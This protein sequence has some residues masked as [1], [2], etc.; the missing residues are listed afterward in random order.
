[1]QTWGSACY[2]YKIPFGDD[3]AVTRE[4]KI[5]C[6]GRGKKE[7]LGF[8][9]IGGIFGFLSTHT[10]VGSLTYRKHTEAIIYDE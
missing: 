8:F 2:N 6:K 10:P 5:G 9:S 4:K 3:S 1:M 7:N